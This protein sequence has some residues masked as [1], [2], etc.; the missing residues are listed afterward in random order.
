MP[1]IAGEG[2]DITYIREGK[3][4]EQ[5]FTPEGKLFFDDLLGKSPIKKDRIRSSD[6]PGS[7][8]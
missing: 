7:K 1:V 5:Y 6:Y 8:Y 2:F 4:F 3:H